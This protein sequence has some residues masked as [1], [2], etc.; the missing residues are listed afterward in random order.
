MEQLQILDADSL[1]MKTK[2]LAV[3]AIQPYPSRGPIQIPH[4]S[5]SPAVNLPALL[6]AQMAD[7]IESLVWNH[8]DPGLSGSEKNRLSDNSDSRKG[9]IFCYT[10]CGHRWPPL[11]N[12][13]SQV[14]Y[15]SE[16]PDVHFC[17]I[18]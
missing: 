10:Q 5:L 11:D 9:E 1:A 6:P 16:I 4:G 7:R 13:L 3:P 15:P 14:Y 17:L 8:F 12:I 18:S 2:D